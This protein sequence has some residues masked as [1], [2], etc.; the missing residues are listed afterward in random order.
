VSLFGSLGAADSKTVRMTLPAFSLWVNDCCLI[1]VIMG[2]VAR[3]ADE[4]SDDISSKAASRLSTFLSDKGELNK[5]LDSLSEEII[6]SAMMG[7]AGY[8]A[9]YLV[10]AEDCATKEVVVDSE[11]WTE[12]LHPSSAVTTVESVMP[13]LVERLKEIT[14]KKVA[15]L[16]W[17]AFCEVYKEGATEV[18]SDALFDAMVSSFESDILP[19]DS[20]Y[21]ELLGLSEWKDLD[22]KIPDKKIPAQVCA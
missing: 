8:E 12:I 17:K 6:T 14:D 3:K 2:V 11:A 20:A 15:P 7:A 19:Y 21:P 5:M 13:G 1:S 22:K 10:S 4:K 9:G 18:P 16:L